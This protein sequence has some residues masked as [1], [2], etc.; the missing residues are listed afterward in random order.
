M[1]RISLQETTD[2]S[3]SPFPWVQLSAE[4]ELR[5]LQ[6]T[7]FYELCQL[8]EMKQ[9]KTHWSHCLH[10]SKQKKSLPRIHTIA[11][12][13]LSK[14]VFYEYKRFHVTHCSINRIWN[15]ADNHQILDTKVRVNICNCDIDPLDKGA[16]KFFEPID[17][18]FS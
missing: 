15:G 9:T 3:Q 7:N 6:N 13:T 11:L 16:S 14:T 18:L 10:F 17:S 4:E 12:P 5:N 8:L 2:L 1:I